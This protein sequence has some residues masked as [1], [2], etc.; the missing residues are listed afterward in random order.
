MTRLRALFGSLLLASALSACAATPPVAQTPGRIT[1]DRQT[2]EL[3]RE[4]VRDKLAARRAQVIERFLGYREARVYPI[5]NLA[6]GGKRHV[7]VDD[8]GNLCAA[9]TLIS[10]DW[11]REVAMRAGAS[12]REIA[13]A[14]VTSG[15]LFDWIL[16]SGL[17]HHEIVAI[18]LPGDDLTVRG[19][20]D[21]VERMYQ[22]YVDVE[23]QLRTLERANLELA[24][25][26][27][28]TRPDLARALLA[29]RVAG[30]GPLT[31]PAG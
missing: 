19:S 1:I 5:N 28:M 20:D 3:D 6:G 18:Q 4:A 2:E 24:V 27:L 15:P 21:E 29:D 17:T 30:P 23:R 12:D 11:G 9:A 26:A 13:L 25:D 7:W 14:S 10:G 31:H 8:W 22:I 16:T